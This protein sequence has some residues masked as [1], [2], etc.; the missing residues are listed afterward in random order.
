[1]SGFSD[2]CV[3]SLATGIVSPIV[4]IIGYGMALLVMDLASPTIRKFCQ[5]C[6]LIAAATTLV[7]IGEAQ[8]L[9]REWMPL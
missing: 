8:K 5:N 2:A 7:R 9:A 6:D 3:P 4:R 1:M